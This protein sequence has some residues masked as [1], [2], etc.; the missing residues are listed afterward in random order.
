M[1]LLND[2]GPFIGEIVPHNRLKTNTE[3][4]TGGGRGER[5]TE[6]EKEKETERE[7]TEERMKKE[8]A[9]K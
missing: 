7:R 2:I 1:N 5:E 3:L 8:K 4:L 6:T 9:R